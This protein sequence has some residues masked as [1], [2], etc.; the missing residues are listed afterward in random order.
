MRRWDY[1][2]GCKRPPQQRLQAPRAGSHPR[3]HLSTRDRRPVLRER[4][5]DVR[6]RGRLTTWRM[7]PQGHWRGSSDRTDCQHTDA[8]AAGDGE[9]VDA[10]EV[11]CCCCCHCSHR[12]RSISHRQ[13]PIS[14]LQAQ[15]T[16]ANLH[17]NC[18]CQLICARRKKRRGLRE[19]RPSANALADTL[20]RMRRREKKRRRRGR[21][22]EV[23]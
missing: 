16:K 22:G 5:A 23:E 7:P 13:P 4:S 17:L 2:R 11:G 12:L 15:K 19:R 21:E 3:R 9:S 1:E 8:A 14:R 6:L 20:R 18:L 10:G